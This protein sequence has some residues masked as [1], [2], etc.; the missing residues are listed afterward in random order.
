MNFVQV[1]NAEGFIHRVAPTDYV[2]VVL[3]KWI[4]KTLRWLEE[5]GLPWP[6]LVVIAV[7]SLC[8]WLLYF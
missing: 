3:M 1:D 7:G 5:I 8:L 6:A 2:I 4:N